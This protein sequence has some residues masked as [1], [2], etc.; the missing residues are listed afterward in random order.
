MFQFKN[1]LEFTKAFSTE[2]KCEKYLIKVRFK[3]EKVKCP[4]CTSIKTW[5]TK[6]RYKCGKCDRSF[7]LKVG[8]IFEGS[9][10]SLRKWFMAIYLLT[11]S[12]KGI[13]SNQLSKE[14]S[15]TQKSCWFMLKRLRYL[16]ESNSIKDA[17]TGTTEVDETHI[18]DLEENKHTHKKHKKKKDIVIG[19]VNRDTKQVKSSK[20]E[21][22]KYIDLAEKVFENVEVGSNLITDELSS[23]TMLR[24]YYNHNKVNHSKGEYVRDDI[25][26]NNTEG[27]FSIVKRTIKRTYHCVSS[28][29]LNKYLS[30]INFRFNNRV[31]NS[32]M[33]FEKFNSQLQ[34]RLK[35]KQVFAY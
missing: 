28:K 4:Y 25:H 13:S 15:I 3:N 6:E 24:I 11:C 16:M 14:L 9:K 23:Y 20:I 31:L 22:I 33:R 18:G 21:G 27:Y 2:L 1:I 19:L 30:E 34:G 29:H 10:I 32:F 12:S 5:K 8:T 26:T 35:Y 17:F 7:T